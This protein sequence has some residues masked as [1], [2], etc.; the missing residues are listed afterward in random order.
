MYISNTQSPQITT[1]SESRL[2][3]SASINTLQTHISD[4]LILLICEYTIYVQNAVYQAL[5][6][7]LK[8][9]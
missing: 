3:N 9:K 4:V 2:D 7:M 5:R 1:L 6:Y 8:A